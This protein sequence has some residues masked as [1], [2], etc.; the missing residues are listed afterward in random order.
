MSDSSFRL[1]ESRVTAIL[2]MLPEEDRE[3]LDAYI[4]DM[5]VEASRSRPVAD[6]ARALVIYG[7]LFAAVVL[8]LWLVVPRI[9]TRDCEV[10]DVCPAPPKPL[11]WKGVD[12]TI[13]QKATTDE[14]TCFKA[15]NEDNVLF[16]VLNPKLPVQAPVVDASPVVVP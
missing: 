13:L 10:C 6:G 9:P 2:K 16:C 11:A 1:A 3:V 12:Y 7:S 5:R 4:K 15:T 8:G 14:M